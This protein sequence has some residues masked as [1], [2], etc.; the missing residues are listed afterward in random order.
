MPSWRTAPASASP[1]IVL[2]ACHCG[3]H[4]VTGKN[5]TAIFG[6]LLCDVRDL[7]EW[8]EAEGHIDMGKVRLTV[9]A[10]KEEARR[11]IDAGM[12][13]R[14]VAKALSISKSTIQ[15]DVRGRVPKA[16]E[17]VPKG[18]AADEDGEPLAPDPR[19]IKALLW[20]AFVNHRIHPL[21]QLSD[22]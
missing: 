19:V 15:R 18:D 8:G 12:R 1:A 10:R 14:K 6:N 4:N 7:G 21:A 22:V 17:S 5:L 9:E 11:L 16:D 20:R 3:R 2:G 13:R